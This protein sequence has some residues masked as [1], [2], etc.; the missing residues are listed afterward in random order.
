MLA[1]YLELATTQSDQSAEI[2]DEMKIPHVK[3]D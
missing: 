2:L 3:K 1:L